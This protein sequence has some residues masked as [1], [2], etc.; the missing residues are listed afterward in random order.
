MEITQH[1]SGELAFEASSLVFIM[2]NTYISGGMKKQEGISNREN[3]F[4]N[5]YPETVLLI[6]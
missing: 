1:V 3:S 2:I 6:Y 4:G 5:R